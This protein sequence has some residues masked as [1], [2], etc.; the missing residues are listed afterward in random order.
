VHQ[1]EIS[2]ELKRNAEVKVQSMH[3][4]T[5]T[6]PKMGGGKKRSKLQV[7]V[8]V[9]VFFCIRN[10]MIDWVP[11]GQAVNQ[12]YYLESLTKLRGRGRKGR[13]SERRNK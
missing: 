2:C 11:E 8:V 1:S 9:I 5:P 7:K 6:A 4:K 12:T 13:N 10:V 3:W